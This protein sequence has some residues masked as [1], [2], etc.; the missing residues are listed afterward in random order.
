VNPRIRGRQ[1]LHDHRIEIAMWALIGQMVISPLADSH[2]R[3]GAVLGLF[4]LAILILVVSTVGNRKVIRFAIYPAAPLWIT[5]R[6]LEA[7]TNADHFYAQL[8]PAAGFVLSCSILVAI[9]DHFNSV[10]EVPRSAFAEAFICYLIISIAFSQLYWFLNRVMDKPFNVTIAANQSGTFLY[11]SMMTLSGVGYGGLLPINPYIRIVA[12][13][14]TMTGIFFVAV[15]VA[16]LV[17]SYQ[18][19][20]RVQHADESNK[21]TNLIKM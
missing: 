9:F 6:L 12:C 8:A 4:G 16:R 20:P 14:E 2:P 17:A 10:P 11:F 3:A 13:L 19:T 5:A 21:E 18:S 7:F 1:F 15:V